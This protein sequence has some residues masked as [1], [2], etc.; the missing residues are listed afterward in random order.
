[1]NG[2]DVKR[3]LQMQ[4]KLDDHIEREHG[5]KEVDTTEEKLLALQVELGE[6]ANET[7]CFKFWSL[8]PASDR[9]VILEEYVDGL[10]FILSLGL[11]FAYDWKPESVEGEETLVSAFLRTFERIAA[12]RNAPTEHHYNVLF[13]TY[14]MLG[15]QLGFSGVDIQSAYEDKNATNHE[16]QE[17]GY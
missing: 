16:R 15:E 6:L 1:M 4:A 13:S 14:L 2:L 11:S 7:R 5:L 17:Q 12:F 3:L 10:H 9:N 8:K